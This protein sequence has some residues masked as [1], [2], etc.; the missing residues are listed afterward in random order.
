LADGKRIGLLGGSFNPAHRAHRH[1]SISALERLALDEVWWLVSP[2]N[3][4]KSTDGMA[5]LKTRIDSAQKVADDARI[6]VTDMETDLGTIYTI[7]TLRALLKRHA[8]HRFVWLMGADNF[9][10][11]PEWKDWR[12]IFR[13]VPI[14]IFPRPT[15]SR[16]A[17]SGKA[18]RRFSKY[19]I[20]DSRAHR[21]AD[22]KAPAWAFVSVKQ[23]AISATLIRRQKG[24]DWDHE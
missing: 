12:E 13:L 20:P 3:P 5:S 4:L 6:H 18:A 15:Y 7:D 23:D 21:L 24:A 1:I 9:I 17:L 11:L 16:R 8:E 22:K 19:R 14:A 10:Q 2:Q